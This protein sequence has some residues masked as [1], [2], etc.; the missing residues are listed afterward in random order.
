MA[1]KPMRRPIARACGNAGSADSAGGFTQ[2]KVCNNDRRS[3][4]G[5]PAGR[6]QVRLFAMSK[7]CPGRLISGNDC[8]ILRDSL[9]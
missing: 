3:L 7:N 4:R 1:P 8:D 9:E 2:S 5:A 6:R